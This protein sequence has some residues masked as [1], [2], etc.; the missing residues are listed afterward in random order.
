MLGSD[1]LF[2]VNVT[3]VSDSPILQSKVI[4]TIGDEK[5]EAETRGQWSNIVA[6]ERLPDLAPHEV[7]SVAFVGHSQLA[8]AS[9]SSIRVALHPA[10]AKPKRYPVTFTL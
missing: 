6:S 3:N 5:V 9:H 1:Y 10:F 8:Y 7:A 4:L 2:R